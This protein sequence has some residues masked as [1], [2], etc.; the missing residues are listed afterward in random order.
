MEHELREIAYLMLDLASALLADD[1]DTSF[2]G[3]NRSD[4]ALRE[5]QTHGRAAEKQ[6]KAKRK[7]EKDAKGMP[8]KKTNFGVMIARLTDELVDA[9]VWEHELS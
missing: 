2:Y 1:A 5:W 3:C 6:A 4:E 8:A 7:R 9:D